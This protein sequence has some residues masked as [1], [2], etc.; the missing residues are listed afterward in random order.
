MGDVE[1][2]AQHVG[3]DW[4]F[5]SNA[6]SAAAER[7]EAL[8]KCLNDCSPTDADIVV[9]G[10]LAR[11]EWTQG[12][13]LDW[14]LLVNGPARP[15]HRTSVNSIRDAIAN[16][17]C[18]RQPGPTE[19]FGGMTFSHDLVHR[20]GGESDTNRTTTQRVLL[21][22]E[23]MRVRTAGD[24][25]HEDVVK[26]VLAA[27]LEDGA[28]IRSGNV[29]RFLL[30]DVVRYWR[31]LGVDFASKMRERGHDGWALR[32]L[33]L[34][35]SRKLIFAAGLVM[36]LEPS[37]G[38]A[39]EKEDILETLVDWAKRT[40]LDTIAKT[41]M[42]GR[43]EPAVAARVFGAYDQFLALLDDPESR[44]DLAALPK[45]ATNNPVY[46][47]ASAI[48]RAFGTAIEDFFFDSKYAPLMRTYG[49]F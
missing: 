49:V 14:T 25:V 33:K 30:N 26:A 31:T 24:D 39:T 12:S 36:A 23:S 45:N 5:L 34:R 21:L 28:A 46:Q 43:V 38:T 4:R 47:R 15:D 22:L 29:P 2:L 20:I 48:G 44:K 17:A 6:R 7:R 19:V 41:A 16:E 13:D 18:W 10:S 32:G 37:F 42:L 27:Y 9:F 1:E 11:C 3:G 40:P 35:T 8:A